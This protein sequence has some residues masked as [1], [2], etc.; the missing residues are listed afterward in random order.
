MPCIINISNFNVKPIPHFT[1][2]AEFF[3]N[4][5][6]Y[7]CGPKQRSCISF[8][9]KRIVIHNKEFKCLFP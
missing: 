1:K 6:G 8:N 5:L 7:I 2:M 4:I 9:S 3:D